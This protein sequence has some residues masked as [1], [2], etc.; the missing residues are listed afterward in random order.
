MREVEE[1]CS[2]DGSGGASQNPGLA[3]KPQAQA[4]DHFMDA[5]DEGFSPGLTYSGQ[6]GRQDLVTRAIIVAYKPTSQESFVL[7][8][9]STCVHTARHNA[10]TRSSM[11]R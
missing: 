6:N 8:L 9:A 10:A 4:M 1:G 2:H 11:M 5:A 3:H 7:P